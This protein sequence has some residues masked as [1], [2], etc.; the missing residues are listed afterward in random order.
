M[1]LWAPGEADANAGRHNG[2]LAF[3]RS[4]KSKPTECSRSRFTPDMKLLFRQHAPATIPQIEEKL[5]TLAED[6]P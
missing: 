3:Y 1:T 5:P 4:V 2:I 6:K